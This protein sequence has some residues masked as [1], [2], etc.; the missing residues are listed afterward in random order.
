M[1]VSN[2][3][4]RAPPAPEMLWLAHA[5]PFRLL[6]LFGLDLKVAF[7]CPRAVRLFSRRSR[8]SLLETVQ[9]APQH[10]CFFDL[11]T[12]GAIRSARAFAAGRS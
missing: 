4:R 7:P 5:P 3:A 6:T 10:G 2:P 9:A 8:P 1:P 11:A 12:R